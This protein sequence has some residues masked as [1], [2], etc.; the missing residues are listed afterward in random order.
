MFTLKTYLP[1]LG[2]ITILIAAAAMINSSHVGAQNPAAP[3]QI[4]N[5]DNPG[6]QPFQAFSCGT[7]SEQTLT[8]QYGNR[9]FGTWKSDIA[10]VP[11]GR[12]LVIEFVTT[13]ANL[14]P[15]FE[16]G[17]P[18]PRIDL[19]SVGTRVGE[20]QGEHVLL[21]IDQSGD[22]I[23]DRV[24]LSQQV[25]GLYANPGTK[26]KLFA[27]SSAQVDERSSVCFS[28]AGYLIDLTPSDSEVFQT[29]SPT[30]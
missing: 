23:P 22:L 7:Y 14:L 9:P 1:A 11:P 10:V 18:K 21:P 4:R 19:I 24:V 17:P 27:R 20:A 3:T 29:P 2:A 26:V 25:K 12:R 28:I 13:R 5:I 16:G 30:P 6:L 8:T 15:F